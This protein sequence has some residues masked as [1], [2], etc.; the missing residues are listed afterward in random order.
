MECV[1]EHD[2]ERRQ[3]QD[4]AAGWNDAQR[5]LTQRA[6]QPLDYYVGYADAIADGDRPLTYH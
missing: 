4:W 1:M 3:I 6:E 5:G 2:T